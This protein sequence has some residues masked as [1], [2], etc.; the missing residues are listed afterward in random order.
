MDPGTWLKI[1][2]L[3][4]AALACEPAERSRL[5]NDAPPEV[6][7]EV[8]L[9]LAQSGSLP[10][11]PV[12]EPDCEAT[13]TQ[14]TA[15]RQFGRYE[16]EKPIGAGG[17]GEVFRARD[18]RLGRSVAIKTSRER[19]SDRFEREA[20]AISA[21]NHPHIC[22][23][24]DVGPDYLVME[25]VEGETLADRLKKG[26]LSTE[27]TLLYATQIAEALAEAHAH[28]IIHRDFKP[29]NI[30]L[31]RHGVKVLDFGLAK[32]L[33][34]PGITGTR[35]VMGTPAY[36]APEQ[37]RGLDA[38]V[39]SDLFSFGLVLYEM[40]AGKLPFPG[41]SLGQMLSTG[42]KAAIPSPSE[43]RAGTPA[44]LDDLI[45]G[46]LRKDPA[47]RPQSASDVARRLSALAERLAAPPRQSRWRPAFAAAAVV[48]VLLLA[49]GGWLYQR[50]EQ[51]RWVREEAIP[52][53][54][55]IVGKQPLAAFLLLRRAEQILPGDEQLAGIEKS[56]TRLASVEST[57]PGA[58]VEIQDYLSP[59]AWF[60][61]GTAP[62]KNLRIPNGYF[63]W[64]ISKPGE[65]EFVA[66]LNARDTMKLAFPR[67]SG[68]KTGTVPVPGGEFADFIDFVGWL[69]YDL[70]A[71]DIDTYE[72]T[73]AQYQQFVDQ[74]GYQKLQ[75]W[76]EK[77]VRDGQTLSWQQAMELFRD[78]TG[79]PGPSTWDAG[80]FP[81]GQGD[82]PVSGVSWYEA[83]AYAEFKGGSLPSI[84]QF[85]KAA[86]P[87]LAPFAINQSNFARH[88]PVKVGTFAGVGPYGTYD[89]AG[90][91]REWSLTAVND[92]RF[93]LGGAWGT[94]TYEAADPGGLP[95]FDRSPMNGFR[96]VHNHAPLSV[97]A[98]A[99]VSMLI[100]DFSRSKPVSD[101]VFEAYKTM[102]AYDRTPLNPISEGIVEDTQAW[103]KEK[104]TF[105]AGYENQRLSAYVFLPKNVH[106]PFQTVVFFPSARV[107]FM[108]NSQNLGDMQFVDYIIKSG[109]ALI[110]PIYAGTYERVRPGWNRIGSSAALQLIV[111]RS[112]E[113][114]RS[115]DYLIT[116]PEIDSSRLAYLGVSMGSA[117]G[118]IFTAL[119]NRFRALVFLDGGLFL[120]PPA[121]GADQVDFAPHVTKPVLMI[122]G[123][124]DFAF[125][126]NRS[127]V[128]LMHMLGTPE[129]DQRRVVLDTPH[130]VSQQKDALSK[131]VLAWLDKYLGRI[132]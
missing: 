66:G 36:M 39:A 51:R 46:L 54:A 125:S 61:M 77:F 115:V 114:R 56:S 106:P 121:R 7:C 33:T 116:R 42:S 113:V 102:Y 107:A 31:T 64:R 99:P 67:V 53:I 96:T 75:Y 84:G 111:R 9:M 41:M 35:A 59:S 65:R 83:A 85:Y 72:V 28:H 63:R 95:P 104:V 81:P 18:T 97:E 26:N 68:A 30:M 12:W 94:Q 78:P 55:R 32:M 126:P 80:H 13:V 120:L 49:G 89:M 127:Q 110:Y 60:P 132:N 3:Y 101:A 5:L 20:R 48:L 122:N 124:Y 123:K 25:L 47:L 117:Y 11:L 57:P 34:D 43:G 17:M 112:K 131:E 86:P 23:L 19:F 52:Q 27:E 58:K 76:K 10:D 105:D 87:D 119:E 88:G 109:R 22:T 8:E 71:F 73:N 24:Y 91:V 128:P 98:A 118:V 38:T 90:N 100:R 1:E 40:K 2:E 45:V 16:I 37:V 69:R 6:R 79:R 44:E 4:H 70:P 82:Y 21:L 74:G 130:D 29:S 92:A 108:T 14:I 15:G 93:I 129:A 62:L 103:T 50:I